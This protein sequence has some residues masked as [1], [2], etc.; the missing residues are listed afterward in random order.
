[1]FQFLKD[2]YFTCFTLFF[3]VGIYRW[4]LP[5]EIGKAVVCVTL[6]EG[7]ILMGIETWIEIYFGKRFL[8][9]LEK[10]AT[11]IAYLTLFLPNYYVLAIR[12]HGIKFERKFTHLTKSRKVILATSF[13]ALLM[14][15]VAFFVY[16]VTVYH[17]YFHIIPKEQ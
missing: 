17:Q 15:T 9:G 2:L 10:L 5:T 3:R 16:S 1:M 4:S 7:I 13:A 11:C 14:A 12:G 6:V 8:F